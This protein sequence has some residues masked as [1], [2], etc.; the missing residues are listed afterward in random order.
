MIEKELVFDE[1]IA[2]LVRLIGKAATA[3]R[4]RYR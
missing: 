1:Q 4:E 3:R 2:C